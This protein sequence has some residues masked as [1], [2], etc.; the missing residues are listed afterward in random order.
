[1]LPTKKS[2]EEIYESAKA[3]LDEVYIKSNGLVS[4]KQCSY[5]ELWRDSI[6]MDFCEREHYGALYCKDGCLH[7]CTQCKNVFCMACLEIE[8][9]YSG[10]NG[11][12][13][14]NLEKWYECPRCG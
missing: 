3:L 5:C 6:E 13:F 2:L 10:N 1:M 14:P 12:Y 4:C 11:V 7:K 8:G 9:T